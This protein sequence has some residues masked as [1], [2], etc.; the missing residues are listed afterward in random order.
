MNDPTKEPGYEVGTLLG[1][2]F[3]GALII[4]HTKKCEACAKLFL[5]IHD[6]LRAQYQKEETP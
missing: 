5:A 3:F 1:N 6:H 4:G 2:A